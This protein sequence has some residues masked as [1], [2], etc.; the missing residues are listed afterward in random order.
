MAEQGLLGAGPRYAK[1]L[2]ETHDEEH[3]VKFEELLEAAI[4]LDRIP[5]EY[6]VCASYDPGLEVIPPSRGLGYKICQKTAERTAQ[7]RQTSAIKL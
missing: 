3:L 6:L 2:A 5:D 7:S 1:V 4:D